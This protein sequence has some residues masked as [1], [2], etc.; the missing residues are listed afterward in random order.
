[1]DAWERN[2]FAIASI[3]RLK[4]KERLRRLMQAPNWDIVIIDEAHHL[5]KYKS[6]KNK[7]R[8]TQNYRLAE[9]LRQKTRDLLLLS[10]TPHQGDEHQFYFLLSLLDDQLFSSAEEV[11]SRRDK[12]DQIMI[13][14]T[15]R[16]VTDAEGK[17]IFA[18]RLVHT[19][20]FTLSAAERRFYD[21]L[22]E[23][24]IEGYNIAESDPGDA[25]KRAVGFVMTTFQKLASSSPRAI[26]AALL[27][28]LLRILIR[29][30]NS[31]EEVSATTHAM[32]GGREELDRVRVRC[33]HLARDIWFLPDTEQGRLDAEQ[34]V[35]HEKRELAKRRNKA[36]LEDAMDAADNLDDVGL[37]VFEA[38]YAGIPDE[39]GKIENLLS[40]FPDRVDRKLDRLL[41]AVDRL[42][43][44]TVTERFIIFTQYR[45]TQEYL[46]EKITERYG[47][48]QVVIIKG[49]DIHEKRKAAAEFRREGGARFLISTSAGG[50]GINLQVCRILFNYDLPWNP[51]T[52]EQRIGRI[53][54]YGQQHT[55]QVFNL[56]ATDTIEGAVHLQLQEKL[57]KIAAAIGK[58]NDDGAPREDFLSSILGPY[59][60]DSTMWPFIAMH[61]ST[62][63]STGQPK[64]L[65]RPCRMPSTLATFSIPFARAW[66]RLIWTSTG[67]FAAT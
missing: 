59:R 2:S 28:H 3:D 10:A 29:K 42:R 49:G 48:D 36:D 7:V 66:N 67:R 64:K 56:V 39:I 51:M 19:E 40:K 5:A 50:E 17:P 26:R 35:L 44:E 12:L 53:H 30:A 63:I 52:I 41:R 60:N 14:R 54:R 4:R 33:I 47:H 38:L 55:A 46:R 13:R 8:T 23:Y 37:E 9:V 34:H 58:V 6:G 11:G 45:Q 61:L 57:Q 21:E 25:Q 18:K 22:N 27:K 31:L 16:E 65:R 1:M 20:G 43:S 15:K 24:L 32:P 62:A